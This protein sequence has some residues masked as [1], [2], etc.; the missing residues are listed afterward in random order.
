MTNRILIST[1]LTWQRLTHD[2]APPF[3]SLVLLL[4]RRSHW[5][6]HFLE[7]TCTFL[8]LLTQLSSLS[9]V[10]FVR[11]GI[12][13]FA[14]TFSILPP[15]FYFAMAFLFCRGYFILPLIFHFAVAVLCCRGFCFVMAFCFAVAFCFCRDTYGLLD[16]S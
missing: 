11:R 15:L 6:L 8:H 1:N 9:C 14:A 12:F 4:P 10:C 5:N 7:Q 2:E 3:V 13:D 16:I